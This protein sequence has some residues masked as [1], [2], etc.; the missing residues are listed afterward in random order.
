MHPAEA[1]EMQSAPTIVTN[2]IIG[3]QNCRAFKVKFNRKYVTK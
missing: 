3:Y 2:R 1:L